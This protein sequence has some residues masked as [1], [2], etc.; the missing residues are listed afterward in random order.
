MALSEMIK[1][2]LE[3][4]L[5]NE[6]LDKVLENLKQNQVV[7]IEHFEDGQ[8]TNLQVSIAREINTNQDLIKSL[9]KII[10]KLVNKLEKVSEDE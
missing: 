9:A 4:R 3:L 5:K 2:L 7:M 1:D 8:F 10:D 6:R